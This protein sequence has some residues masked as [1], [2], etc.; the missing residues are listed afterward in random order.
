M[1]KTRATIRQLLDYC[2]M[3]EEAVLAYKASN[4][5]LAVHSNA[6]YCNKKKSRSR[7]GGHFSLSNN[8]KLPPNNGAIRTIATVIKAVM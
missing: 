4:M 7:V 2:A 6:G 3:Q 5:I 1:E 8:D